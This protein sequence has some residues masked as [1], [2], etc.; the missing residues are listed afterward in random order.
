M[1]LYETA[2]IPPIDSIQSGTAPQSVALERYA[3]GLLPLQLQGK[4]WVRP[5]FS[6]ADPPD[7]FSGHGTATRKD[8]VTYTD[9][10]GAVIV[11]VPRDPAGSLPDCA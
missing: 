6:P 8:V 7:G 2:P 5:P 3:C 10:L 9:R 1:R 4:E 11:L